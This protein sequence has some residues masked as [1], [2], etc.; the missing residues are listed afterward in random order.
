[1]GRKKP[2]NPRG[3]AGRVGDS[4]ALQDRSRKAFDNTSQQELVQQAE[5]LER[6]VGRDPK[7]PGNLRATG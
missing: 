2:K 4:E 5:E 6:F 7:K 3:F 1:M